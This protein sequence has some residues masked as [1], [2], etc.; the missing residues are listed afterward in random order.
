MA[1]SDKVLDHFNNPRNAGSFDRKDVNIGTGV[2]GAPE[3]GDVLKLQIKVDGNN[4]IVEVAFV[5]VDDLVVAVGVGRRYQQDDAI[6]ED[7]AGARVVTG[8]EFVG[9]LHGHL[10]RG[11]F[12]GVQAAGYED[13]RLGLGEHRQ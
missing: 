11:A 6:V 8:G 4:K 10:R 3:C 9:E 5:P 2:V 7:L 13:G 1:Y 12:A